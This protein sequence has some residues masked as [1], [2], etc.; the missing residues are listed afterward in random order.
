[1]YRWIG[2]L[3]R[4]PARLQRVS[5]VALALP[6]GVVFSLVTAIG[7]G[8]FLCAHRFRTTVVRNIGELLPQTSGRERARMCRQ[9]IVHQCLTVYEQA[10]E[11][12][13]GLAGGR[14]GV[15]FR[16]DG[17]HYLDDALRLGRGAI[18][19]TPHVGNYF[20]C[21]WWLA[22]RYRCATVVTAGSPELRPLFLG[23]HALGLDAWDYDAEAPQELTRKLRRHLQ[24]NGVVFLLGDVSRPGFRDGTLFGKPSPM[25]A[26]AVTLA[27]RQKV[28]IVPFVGLRHGWFRHHLLFEAPVC[29]HESYTAER[30]GDALRALAQT[31]ERLI[32]R[33]PQQWLYWFNVHERWDTPPARTT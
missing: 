4:T 31:M 29:L 3:T 14:T 24:A 12:K 1:M 5:R 30:K 2:V 18:V 23:F 22:Q 25:P 9:Y 21:Y 8:A 13:R 6:R 7:W 17:E 20:Y 11:Y 26:G 15:Q 33:A 10:I 19:F 27:L 32:L 28:P 16:A